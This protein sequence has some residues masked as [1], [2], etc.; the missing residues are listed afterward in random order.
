M[1]LHLL[2]Y[3]LVH[4]LTY[5]IILAYES[6]GNPLS[7]L[8]VNNA[9]HD[10]LLPSDNK[11]LTIKIAS[12]YILPEG[13]YLLTYSLTHVIIYL[14]VPICTD[15]RRINGLSFYPNYGKNKGMKLGGS[16]GTHSLT[17]AFIYSFTHSL[18]HCFT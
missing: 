14:L 11:D 1:H 8:A 4:L 16:S 7:V 2:T 10:S 13:Y 9:S 15:L 18:I 5:L 3:S 12:S 6:F 17:H